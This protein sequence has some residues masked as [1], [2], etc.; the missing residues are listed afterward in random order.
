MQ[1]I[2]MQVITGAVLGWI[3]FFVYAFSMHMMNSG[4]SRLKKRSIFQILSG[5]VLV[6][7]SAGV[8][9][10]LP[11]ALLLHSPVAFI[12]CAVVGWL[13]WFKNLKF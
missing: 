6:I 7:I 12:S 5:S 11:L 1:E 2:G 8:L 10:G 3:S 13:F 4:K 9:V